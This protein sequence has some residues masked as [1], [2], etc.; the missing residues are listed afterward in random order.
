MTQGPNPFATPLEGRDPARRFRG[1][2]A[3]PVTLWTA[4][5]RTA[6]AGLTISSLLV[7]EGAPSYVVAAVNPT[8]ELWEALEATRRCVVHVLE[9]RHR[10]LA[11]RF[12]GLAPS[13]GGL[14]LGVSLAHTAWGPQ[15]VDAKNRAY[16]RVEGSS[17]L[18]YGNLVRAVVEEVEVADLDEPLVYFRGRHR[19]LEATRRP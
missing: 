11:E 16:C 4:G 7:A 2:L 12:A 18:G 13:P 19:R 6:P 3:A 8:T 17:E 9:R 5:A 10:Q 15:I 14:F 1:R